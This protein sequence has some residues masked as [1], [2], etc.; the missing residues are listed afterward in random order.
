M[1][2]A[3][4]DDDDDDD[5]DGESEEEEETEKSPIDAKM[6]TA[7]DAVMDRLSAASQNLMHTVDDLVGKVQ[8]LL[9]D[10]L[11]KSGKG[12]RRTSSAS[13][14]DAEPDRILAEL[15]R[16]KLESATDKQ[17]AISQTLSTHVFSPLFEQHLPTVLKDARSKLL[18]PT[19][20]EQ[21]GAVLLEQL[22]AAFTE[23]A[24]SAGKVALL[25][26]L[27]LVVSKAVG[28]GCSYAKSN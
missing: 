24:L 20:D 26:R 19:G 9:R 23:R 13:A 16:T 11:L 8:A 7:I 15:L 18:K 12:A 5:S 22:L 4:D 2:A 28:A 14:L 21:A 27:S 1:V 10:S 17:A 6:E 25:K 3:A